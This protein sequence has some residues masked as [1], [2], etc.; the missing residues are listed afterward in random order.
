MIVTEV[1]CFLDYYCR[2][3]CLFPSYLS[4]YDE[5]V[6]FSMYRFGDFVF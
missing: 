5:V 2:W 4:I 6:G 1:V 3:Y